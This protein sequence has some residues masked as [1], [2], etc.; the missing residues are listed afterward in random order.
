ML[1]VKCSCKSVVEILSTLQL[2]KRKFVVLFVSGTVEHE[3]ITQRWLSS[4]TPH[5]Y[6]KHKLPNRNAGKLKGVIFEGPKINLL[7][8]DTKF[9]GFTTL[10]RHVTDSDLDCSPNIGDVSD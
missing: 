10:E 9:Q 1:D 4:V 8:R 7:I 6:F 3:I 5:S 2:G